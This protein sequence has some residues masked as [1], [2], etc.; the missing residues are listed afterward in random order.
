M[1]EEAQKSYEKIKKQFLKKNDDSKALASAIEGLLDGKRILDA[2]DKGS[3]SKSKSSSGPKVKP[4][5]EDDPV[6]RSLDKLRGTPM[7]M[8]KADEAVKHK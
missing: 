7:N 3:S 1:G 2:N 6:Q 8:A 4:L 5:Y